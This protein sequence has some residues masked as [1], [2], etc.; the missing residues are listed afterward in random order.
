VHVRTEW[1]LPVKKN[2]IFLLKTQNGHFG[3]LEWMMPN[4]HLKPLLPEN[5]T[6]RPSVEEQAKKRNGKVY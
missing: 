4:G 3:V 1:E 2:I 5:I 6:I